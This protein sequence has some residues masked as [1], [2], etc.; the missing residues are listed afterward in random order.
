MAFATE[1]ASF[2]PV[3]KAL[4]A[5]PAKPES[6]GAAINERPAVKAERR[7]LSRRLVFWMGSISR[8]RGWL[9]SKPERVA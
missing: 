2:I 7:S 1:G 8:T 5:V 3:S 9:I 4:A 6:S